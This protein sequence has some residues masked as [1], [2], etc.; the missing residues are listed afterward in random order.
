MNVNWEGLLPIEGDVIV[1]EDDPTLRSLMTDILAEIGANTLA[2]ETADDALTHLLQN[3]G[4]CPLVIVDQGL[5]GQIQGIEFIE[6]IQS[7]WPSIASILTSG[8]LI[9]P[10]DLP[11][12]TLYLHK[13]WSL[14]DLV[15]SVATVMQPGI[16]IYPSS[17]RSF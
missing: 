14:N 2:F 16:P 3:Q 17:D 7:R 1:V 9:N 15:L 12:A 8:Y 13:P 11:A 4:S 5:P 6:L 10:T